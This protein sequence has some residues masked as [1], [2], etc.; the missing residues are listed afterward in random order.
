MKNT[1]KEQLINYIK[2]LPEDT[3]LNDPTKVIRELISINKIKALISKM[4]IDWVYNNEKQRVECFHVG[5]RLAFIIE[6]SGLIIEFDVKFT[7]KIKD[8][9]IITYVAKELNKMKYQR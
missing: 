4:D 1:E 3:D 5:K 2:A 6:A 9:E 8:L 7:F